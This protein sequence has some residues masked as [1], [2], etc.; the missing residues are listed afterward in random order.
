M[1]NTVGDTAG[2][3]RAQL[4]VRA[5]QLAKSC[6]YSHLRES[7]KEPSMQRELATYIDHRGVPLS[8]IKS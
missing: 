8:F 1:H 5:P 7:G 6:Y 2:E 4:M 3:A